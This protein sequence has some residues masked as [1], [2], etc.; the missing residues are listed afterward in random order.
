MLLFGFV[1]WFKHCFLPPH[2]CF[3]FYYFVLFSLGDPL[4]QFLDNHPNPHH[5]SPFV[6]NNMSVCGI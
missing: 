4:L 6:S 2:L 1:F 5:S 3:S